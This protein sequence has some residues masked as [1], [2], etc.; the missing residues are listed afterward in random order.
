MATSSETFLNH[1]MQYEDGMARLYAL[2]A[3]YFYESSPFWLALHDEE[4]EHF[5]MMETMR[6]HAAEGKLTFSFDRLSAPAVYEALL[7]FKA[8]FALA[9]RGPMPMTQAYSMAL[10]LEDS[11]IERRI[12][13]IADGDSP[14]LAATLEMLADTYRRHARRLRDARGELLGT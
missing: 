6:M 3:D 13:E 7:Y 8:C 1:L 14:E 4:R 12:F 10:D 9:Q 5:E 11:L 2:F